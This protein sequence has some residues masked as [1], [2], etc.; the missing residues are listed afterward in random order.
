[1]KID[2]IEIVDLQSLEPVPRIMGS[3]LIALA[4]FIGK[5]R[6]ID[7]TIIATEETE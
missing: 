4:A 5:T 1:L 6:L 2:Y 3:A 7:N